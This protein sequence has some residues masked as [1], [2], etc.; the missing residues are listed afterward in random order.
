[1]SGEANRVLIDT[2]ARLATV[3]PRNRM[4]SRSLHAGQRLDLG[5]VLGPD[6]RTGT[7]SLAGVVD[8]RVAGG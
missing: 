5:V 1:M 6:I 2:D 7:A 8:E 4:L 3:S